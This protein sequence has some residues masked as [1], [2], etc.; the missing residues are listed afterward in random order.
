MAA[1]VILISVIC[2]YYSADLFFYNRAAI[3]DGQYWRL[4]SGHFTH[5]NHWHLFFNMSGWVIIFLLGAWCLSYPTWIFLLL[6]YLLAISVLMYFF[7]PEVAFYGGLSGVLHGFFLTILFNWIRQGYRIAFLLFILVL[8]KVLYETFIQD[9]FLT[10]ELM[11]IEIVTE[12]HLFGVLVALALAAVSVMSSAQPLHAL[13]KYRH[14]F[15][16]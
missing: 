15:E 2:T 7:T 9:S 1:V 10:D 11:N 16:L 3:E 4:F 12:A 6:I 13:V 8:F 14:R 5:L